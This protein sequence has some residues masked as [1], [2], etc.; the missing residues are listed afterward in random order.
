VAGPGPPPRAR[1][2]RVGWA[3]LGWLA[4][5]RGERARAVG[6]VASPPADPRTVSQVSPQA[7][8]G[9]CHPSKVAWCAAATVE[10]VD[11]G[12]IERYA[13]RT[14]PRLWS[15][16]LL[17]GHHSSR[18]A[19]RPAFLAPGLRRGSP[20]PGYGWPSGSLEVPVLALML[21]LDSR[22]C[23]FCHAPARETTP[24]LSLRAQHGR[25]RQ[26]SARSSLSAGGAST[27]VFP[28]LTAKQRTRPSRPA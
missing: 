2:L 21:S 19:A 14:G 16:S 12:R 26:G 10:T 6:F 3:G 5:A 18:P 24:P 1:G 13:D 15:A 7:D 4:G 22:G 28:P 11:I 20:R 25:G 27:E 17:V 8:N 23:G 9:T